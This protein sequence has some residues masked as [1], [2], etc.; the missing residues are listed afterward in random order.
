MEGLV[1]DF[2]ARFVK[3][4]WLFEREGSINKCNMFMVR[5]YRC[6]QCFLMQTSMG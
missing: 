2:E 6:N 4:E 3:Y 1:M 5:M